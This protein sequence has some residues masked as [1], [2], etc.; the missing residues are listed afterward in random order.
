MVRVPDVAH[1]TISVAHEKITFDNPY[2]GKIKFSF[3]KNEFFKNVRI[4]TIMQVHELNTLLFL[5]LL[6]YYAAFPTHNLFVFLY[7]LKNLI[8]HVNFIRYLM[9]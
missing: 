1:T 4:I 5:L 8:L 3:V 7:E 9:Q 2:L 6:R